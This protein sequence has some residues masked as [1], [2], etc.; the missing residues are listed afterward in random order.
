[1]LD[2]A[3]KNVHMI[4]PDG[5]AYGGLGVEGE[6]IRYI[7]PAKELPNARRVVDGQEHL[8]IPGFIDPHVHL[9]QV[10]VPQDA[11]ILG[12]NFLHETRAALRGGVTT[13]GVFS[14][15]RPSGSG[16]N[17][18]RLCR[19]IGEAYSFTDFFFHSVISSEKHVWEIPILARECGVWS[20]KHFFNANKPRHPG[21]DVPHAHCEHALL[22]QS[23]QVS[24]QF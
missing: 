24:P 16:I 21:E 20:F 5:V 9:G 4:T 7:G 17:A 23:L 6:T 10:G 2:L 8:A 11:E 1:M 22:F 12:Q 19:E 15:P 3:I 18:V 13:V 14:A